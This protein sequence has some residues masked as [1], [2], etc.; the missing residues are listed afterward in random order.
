MRMLGLVGMAPPPNNS[1]T[2]PEHRIYPYLLRGVNVMR[3]NQVWWSD[4]SVP[5]K[6]V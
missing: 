4:I 3:P 5:Q 1:K 2:H 6:P